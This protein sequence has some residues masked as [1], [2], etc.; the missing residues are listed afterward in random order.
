MDQLRRPVHVSGDS[1]VAV[2]GALGVDA[3]SPAAVRES[4]RAADAASP[5]PPVVVVRRSRGASVR[6][7]STA[8]LRLED[9]THRTVSTDGGRAVVPARL[10]LG[11]HRLRTADRGNPG[12]GPPHPNTP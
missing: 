7:G 10:P 4:L 3:S 9:G 12:R 11:W 2:L 8:L 6:V 5:T 1:V